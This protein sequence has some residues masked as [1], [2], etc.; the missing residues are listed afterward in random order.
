MPSKD[1][2]KDKDKEKDALHVEVVYA[3][4]KTQVAIEIHA[5]PGT[6]VAQAIR[7]SGIL[8]RLPEISLARN[9]VGIFGETT[10]LDR[11]VC[12]GDRVEIYRPLIADPKEARR[13]RASAPGRGT[14]DK[15]KKT[16]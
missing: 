8:E 15:K 9:R 6:T 12:A 4:P 1:K 3:A 11:Q 16:D 7:Q 2:D 10:S 13:L 5:R 14:Q